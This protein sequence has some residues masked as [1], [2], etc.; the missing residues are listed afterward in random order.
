MLKVSVISIVAI[1]LIGSSA[2]VAIEQMQGTAAGLIGL[3]DLQHGHQSAATNQNLCLDNKQTINGDDVAQRFMGNFIQVGE[4]CGDCALVGIGLELQVGG[5]QVQT[6]GSCVEAKMETQSLNLGA[7]QTLSR[8]GGGGGGNAT[9]VAVLEERQ[10]ASNA[11]GWMNEKSNVV[12]MQNS[13][14][15]GSAGATSATN[16]GMSVGVLQSQASF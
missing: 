7:L 1:L 11:A 12:A 13:N 14:V 16:T 3:V 10:Q 9:H 6:V 8:A 15:G 5:D 2:A 4:A